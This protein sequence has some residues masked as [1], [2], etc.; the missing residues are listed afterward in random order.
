MTIYEKL[1]V[2]QAELRLK[3]Q[4]SIPLASTTSGLLKIYWK[5]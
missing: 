1:S 5:P 2:I 4:G 3:N